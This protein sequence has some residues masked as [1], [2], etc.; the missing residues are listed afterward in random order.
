MSTRNSQS[1]PPLKMP[2]TTAAPLV[3]DEAQEQ[4]ESNVRVVTSGDFPSPPKKQAPPIE[5][6]E[7]A[8][9]LFV[10]KNPI[11]FVIIMSLII[12]VVV[13]AIVLP[14]TLVK[15]KSERPIKPKCPDGKNQPRIDCLPD[16]NNLVASGANLESAC[17][18]RGCCWSVTP[19]GGGPNCAFHFN[20]G[21]K[22]KKVRESSQTEHWYELTR[23]E[24]PGSLA[25]SDIANLEFKLEAHTDYRLRIRVGNEFFFVYF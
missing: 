7:N 23:M 8:A 6:D 22:Q 5:D 21:F 14:L 16:R 1:P 12:I 20:Y 15:P 24:A 3:S 2:G 4:Q 10:R 19:E 9:L 17:R 25:R 18:Q 11:L 13:L